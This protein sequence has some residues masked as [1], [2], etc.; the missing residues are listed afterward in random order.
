[1]SCIVIPIVEGHGEVGAVPLLLRRIAGEL[2][3]RWDLH[4]LRPIRQPRGSLLK[5]RESGAPTAFE[6]ALRF[7]ELKRAQHSIPGFTLVLLDADDDCPAEMASRLLPRAG[8]HVSVVFAK[9]EFETWFAASAESLTELLTIEAAPEDPERDGLA[10]GWV[11]KRFRGGRY[12]ESVDQAR[13]VS[14]MD[15]G[16]AR[17]RSPSFDKLC[18]EIEGRLAQHPAAD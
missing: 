14:R 7:A 3:D 11:D 8:P 5:K 9:R 6:N 1:M 4:V 12:S 18:R 2:L 10:K 16:L 13:L 17:R 15:L